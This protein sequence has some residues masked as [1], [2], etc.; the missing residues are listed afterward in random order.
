MI[1]LII[2]HFVRRTFAVIL[3]SAVVLVV[4]QTIMEVAVAPQRKRE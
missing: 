3:I 2:V 1:N 4:V